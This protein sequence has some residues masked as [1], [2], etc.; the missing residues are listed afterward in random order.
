MGNHTIPIL[1]PGGPISV[2]FSPF[3]GACVGVF[4]PGNFAGDAVSSTHALNLGQFTPQANA[5]PQ[6]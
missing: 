4:T 1:I 3:P 2:P 6:N 5:L